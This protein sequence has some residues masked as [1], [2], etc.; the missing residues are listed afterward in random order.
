MTINELC[1]SF[2]INLQLTQG[3][4]FYQATEKESCTADRRIVLRHKKKKIFIDDF[5]GSLAE[6]FYPSA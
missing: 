3:A 4:G 5:T 2:A 6:T 1:M